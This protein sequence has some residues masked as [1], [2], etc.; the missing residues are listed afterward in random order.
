MYPACSDL[1]S[2]LDNDCNGEP[3]DGIDF[4][5]ECVPGEQRICGTALNACTPRVE[6]CEATTQGDQSHWGPC[7][8]DPIA[9]GAPCDD[10]N[11]QTQA[12]W[13]LAGVCAGVAVGALA[14]GYTQSCSV[15]DDGA[16]RCWGAGNADPSAPLAP[17]TIARRPVMI[18]L[19]ASHACALVEDGPPVCWG[20]NA[21]G[22]LGNGMQDFSL[23]NE[24]QPIVGLA[25]ARLLSAT[26]GVTAAIDMAGV[27]F[28]WGS[29]TEANQVL[30]G[31]SLPPVTEINTS[32]SGVLV[33]T[34]VLSLPQARQLAVGERHA[35][36]L[37]DTSQVSCWGSNDRGQLGSRSP[38]VSPMPML[39]PNVTGAVQVDAG[40]DSCALLKDGHV[41]CWGRGGYG[42]SSGARRPLVDGPYEV[43][44]LSDIVQIS[45]I[46]EAACALSRNSSVWCWGSN[47]FGDLGDGTR[48]DS[49]IPVQVA[50]L[51][52]AAS[53]GDTT[54]GQG[55]H[56]C[57][58]RANNAVLCWGRNNFGQLGDGSTAD[59]DVPV[60]V[61]GLP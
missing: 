32:V 42:L 35:C 15:Q 19:G 37:L 48:T 44:G 53:I 50:G 45:Q 25:S 34:Q 33:P 61:V 36:A 59:R 52:D 57:A 51:T 20:S 9:D 4:A 24:A 58:R 3:D 29:Y 28:L 38:D 14:T 8:Y 7:G 22:E 47:Q 41:W 23:T 60:P 39:V 12:D 21:G 1:R 49:E 30:F 26:D 17:V 16:I 46:E 13:C 27:L 40:S 11:G 5:C 56:F 10:G 6:V 2:K 18:T 55:N 31:A 54:G 43:P